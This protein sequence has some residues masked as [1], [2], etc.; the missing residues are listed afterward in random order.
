MNLLLL[1]P[2]EIDAD[3]TA[4]LDD[5][6]AE[7]IRKVL[8]AETGRRLRVGVIGEGIGEGRVLS[9][10]GATVELAVEALGEPPP[11]WS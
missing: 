1:E 6:R 5:R 8:R 11:R 4:R 7:H 3:G 10:D 9:I 2:D